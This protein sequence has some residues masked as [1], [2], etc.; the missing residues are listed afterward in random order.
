MNTDLQSSND[1]IPSLKSES[2]ESEEM[3]IIDFENELS[4]ELKE[5]EVTKH[6]EP[7]E[8]E[9][10]EPVEEEN[11]D[12]KELTESKVLSN[13]TYDSGM[14]IEEI[15]DIHIDKNL[16]ETDTKSDDID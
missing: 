15:E 9:V 14:I 5:L 8:E 2:T 4:E 13:T 7:V 10:E 3:V 12:M 16:L 6:K 11:D 1:N